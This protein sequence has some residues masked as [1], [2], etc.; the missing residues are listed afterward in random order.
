MSKQIKGLGL[1]SI[2]AFLLIASLSSF[3]V[4]PPKAKKLAKTDRAANH[5]PNIV[6]T[7]YWT[8]S[9]WT[10]TPVF[11]CGGNGEVCAVTFN[12]GSQATADA[13]KA[14][15]ENSGYLN[16]PSINSANVTVGSI[17]CFVEERARE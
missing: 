10:F 4:D 17:T 12:N 1:L 13:A 8:G 7:W 6:R 15:Y 3:K 9:T 14:S 11:E 2:L 5:A 16:N